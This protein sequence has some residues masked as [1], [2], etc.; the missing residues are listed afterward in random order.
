MDGMQNEL[1]VLREGLE[2]A[3]SRLDRF[4][5][6][7]WVPIEQ[8]HP[9]P[10]NPR[11]VI[12]EDVVEAIV[13][14]IE[15]NGEFDTCHAL[16]VRPFGGAYQVVSGH[17]R[18]IAAQ[19]IGLTELPC[20]VRNLSDEDAFMQL[21]KCNAQGE[22][23]PLEY[24]IHALKYVQLSEGGRGK[25]GGIREYCREIGKH[26][27]HIT[28]CKQAAEVTEKLFAQVNSLQVSSLLTKSKHLAAIY[29]TPEGDWE[30]LVGLMI[31]EDWSVRE[32]EAAVSALSELVVDE[33]LAD[34]LQPEKKK[35][36][37]V[38]EAVKGKTS[39][40]A[41]RL[42][43]YS[44]TAIAC[45]E[46]L[47]DCRPVWVF[48]DG[49]PHQEDWN[50]QAMFL[51]KLKEISTP[52]DKKIEKAK[53]DIL[54]LVGRLD[55]EYTN[56]QL[57]QQSEEE[58]R[59]IK[60]EE[61]RKNSALKQRYTPEGFN[62]SI[63]DIDLS[64]YQFDAIITDPPYLVSTGG[65][66]VRS[67]KETCVDKNFDDTLPPSEW[68]PRVVDWLKPGGALVAT[69]NFTVLLELCD[70]AKSLGMEYTKNFGVW[71]IKNTPPQLIPDRWKVDHNYLFVAYKPG[72]KHYFGYDEYRERY[73]DQPA[74]TICLPVCGGGERLGWHDTQK[75][76][77]LMER[78]IILFCP[79]DGILL[80][81]FSGTGTTP[82]VA[83]RIQRRAVW[84]EKDEDF[85]I[86]A[87]NRIAK[88]PFYWEVM[89]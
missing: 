40:T 61:E 52:S 7:E 48:V 6:F 58:A 72:D 81:P 30:W 41:Q 85:Y 83:K 12:R 32:T 47:S 84:V 16:V 67:G 31:A 17:H 55:A 63:M 50:L 3:Y 53:T 56:W 87:E 46:S 59:R 11:M 8:I 42:T 80:E 18:L 69:C 28:E 49:K 54:E 9:H 86:K 89:E 35:L 15:S 27:G 33:R 34:W 77:G 88:T 14:G 64:Q 71:Y 37:V 44:K 4:K 45:L 75:P 5:D 38:K 57:Q 13:A 23:S 39:D 10:D 2:D 19:R 76:E 51:D 60:E 62:Q 73:G 26:P 20:W 24:G 66:T 1:Q 68:M 25:K 29:K 78:L 74:S 70:V 36:E 79:P 82:A 43:R 65:T 21:V 22:L